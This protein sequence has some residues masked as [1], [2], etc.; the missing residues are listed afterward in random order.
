MIELYRRRLGNAAG[1]DKVDQLRKADQAERAL[2]LIG[3]Q[4]EREEIFNLARHARISDKTSRK[5]VREI[6]LVES[7]YR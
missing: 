3:L 1:N 6:D 5:L 4:A 2:R 7:R